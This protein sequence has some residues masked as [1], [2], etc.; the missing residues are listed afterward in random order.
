MWEVV[1]IIVL[2][3]LCIF[4]LVVGFPLAFVILLDKIRTPRRARQNALLLARREAYLRERRL[5]LDRERLKIDPQYEQTL[6]DLEAYVNAD[7]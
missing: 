7:T 3:Y 1:V 6:R 5:R 4:V 2:A